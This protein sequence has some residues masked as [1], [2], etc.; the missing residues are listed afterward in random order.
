MPSLSTESSWFLRAS[1]ASGPLRSDPLTVGSPREPDGHVSAQQDGEAAEHRL[2]GF[3][4]LG[5]LLA[6][7]VGE[8][9]VV[10]H[11]RADN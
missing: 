11:V 4:F 6:D 3:A 2:L 7:A 10:G 8:S 9:L 5:E 1:A